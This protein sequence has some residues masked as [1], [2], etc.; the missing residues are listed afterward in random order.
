MKIE[1]IFDGLDDLR[2]G[3]K[4]LAPLLN[5]STAGKTQAPAP[6]PAYSSQSTAT[7]GPFSTSAAPSPVKPA[8]AAKPA[9]PQSA[10]QMPGTEGIMT[11]PPE[12]D[13]PADPAPRLTL[14]DVRRKLSD[15]NHRVAR[16]VA[17]EI[18]K[19]TA[20]V[21][22]LTDVPEDQLA[23]VAAAADNWSDTNAPAT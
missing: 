9:A 23:A 7:G 5:A 18:I 8:A 6:N 11:F 1:L 4:S 12:T 13:A 20:G 3:L 16:N 21:A 15:L 19:S 14:V 17:A 2:A 22:R 10:E